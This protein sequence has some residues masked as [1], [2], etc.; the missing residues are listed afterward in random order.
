MEHPTNGAVAE[1]DLRSIL[2]RL[3]A[4]EG[5][6]PKIS[7]RRRVGDGHPHYQPIE[8]MDDGVSQG[9]GYQL[10]ATSGL[11]LTRGTSPNNRRLT[12]SATAGQ[13]TF[14]Y[15]YRV[16][17]SW[18]GTEG[19]SFTLENTT[20]SYKTYSTVKSA[21]D[22]ANA[23]RQTVGQSSSFFICGG[24]YQEA[25]T[26]SI[27]PPISGSYHFFGVGRDRVTIE[28]TMTS[29]HLFDVATQASESIVTMSEIMLDTSN[30]ITLLNGGGSTRIFLDNLWFRPRNNDAIALD[31]GIPG[32]GVWLSDFLIEGSG[33]GIAESG[34]IYG[35]LHLANG[36]ISTRIGIETS[37]DSLIFSSNVQFSCSSYDVLISSAGA[38]AFISFTG[39][40]YF[41]R[42]CRIESNLAVVIGSLIYNGCTFNLGASEIGVDFASATDASSCKAF[43][44]VGN[45]LSGASGAIGVRGLA[46]SGPTYSVVK[47]NTFEG[48]TSG[49]EIVDMDHSTNTVGNNV[50]DAGAISESG[51]DPT[52]YRV[53]QQTM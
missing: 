44:F 19:Q 17:S 47:A 51:V 24:L 11:T 6:M 20:H 42:G 39:G 38:N 52:T 40:C 18:T 36:Y 46:G 4:L 41:T 34:G 5:K 14:C 25:T 32:V 23:N 8:G 33:L 28:G 7:E 12:L 43:T 9:L 10:D 29:G 26:I 31:P 45:T 22:D 48:F 2:A 21:V 15:D 13:G 53:Y 35:G 16:I 27:D 3:E 1:V 50:S 30:A 37:G 49:N